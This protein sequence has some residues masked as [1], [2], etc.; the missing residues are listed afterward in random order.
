MGQQECQ[1]RHEVPGTYNI[2]VLFFIEFLRIKLSLHVVADGWSFKKSRFVF[3]CVCVC[4]CVCVLL[5]TEGS[6]G[7]AQPPS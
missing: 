7:N 5:L 1:A 3:A 2:S 4:V 6:T